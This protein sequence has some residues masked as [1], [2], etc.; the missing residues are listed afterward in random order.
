MKYIVKFFVIT[1][2]IFHFTHTFAEG[3]IVFINMDYILNQSKS[4]KSAQNQLEKLHKSNLDY[5]NKIEN[6]LKNEEKDILSKKN[7]LKKEEFEAQIAK[8]RE[9]A[10][11]YQSSRVK[12][13][14]ELTQ[15][16][17]KV[18]KKILDELKPILA[19]YIEEETISVILDKKNVIVGKI[20]LDITETIIKKLDNKLPE[21]KIN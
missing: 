17:I 14:N 16:R 4:G 8:L 6:K 19:K 5:L 13:T 1:F 3:K 11:E 10:R 21:I 15:K 12:L 9:D 7:I 20:N 2:F 18:T